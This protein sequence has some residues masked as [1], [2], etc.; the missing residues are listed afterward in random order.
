MILARVLSAF[1]KPA[2]AGGIVAAAAT[3][4][5]FAIDRFH[6]DSPTPFA[7]ALDAGPRL[8]ISEF[9]PYSDTI[10]AVNPD[11]VGDRTT[12]ATVE[13]AANFGVFPV[14]SPDG[15]AI[16]WTG[17]PAQAANP[18]P[19]A[20]ATLGMIT[21]D[22]GTQA[23]ADDVDL[24]VPPVWAP[25]SQSVLAR[26]STTDADGSPRFDLLRL[27][28][29]G[30]RATLTTWTT[31]AL[32]PVGFSPDGAT[33]Y[34][35]TLNASGSDL[36]RIGAD[37]TGEALVAHLADDITR[38]W[39]L[40]PDGGTLAFTDAVGGAQPRTVARVLDLAS[41]AIADAPDPGDGSSQLAPAFAED[42]TL[43][44]GALRPQGGGTAVEVH[45]DGSASTLTDT[46]AD[47]D[48]PIAWSPDGSKLAVRSVEDAT[49]YSA[50]PSHID[51]VD[52]AGG[53]ARVSDG[54]DTLVVGWMR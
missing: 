31:A 46:G 49:S 5:W 28:R 42:G 29:D 35:T 15:A 17:L 23:L 27:G 51:L 3:G 39:K 1:A 43:A 37:A 54:A 7:Q 41:G 52:A 30:S 2:L 45:G 32:F 21:A 47:I 6:H 14:L 33:V 40:S 4:G 11:D 12:I 26:K 53:R 22:G 10:V 9:G 38:D 18:S 24:V 36:Y 50:G 25:D 16:A 34:F 19:D 8:V 48:L 44:I 20:P 13:H